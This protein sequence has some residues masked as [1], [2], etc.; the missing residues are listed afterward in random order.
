MRK[1]IG[2]VSSARHHCVRAYMCGCRIGTFA[3]V[4]FP[5]VVSVWVASKCLRVAI[6]AAIAVRRFA[7]GKSELLLLIPNKTIH[8]FPPYTITPYTYTTDPF[9][10]GNLFSICQFCF[11]FNL[12]KWHCAEHSNGRNNNDN[13]GA[14]ILL[15]T[16]SFEPMQ[17]EYVIYGNWNNVGG[18]MHGE[19]NIA[20]RACTKRALRATHRHNTQPNLLNSSN[21]NWVFHKFIFIFF[22]VHF[23]VAISSGDG[24]DGNEWRQSYQHWSLKG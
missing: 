22:F 13:N 20:T 18:F 19:T 6:G 15:T 17:Y 11:R 21:S 16:F 7:C 9:L 3:S 5:N 23:P 12:K 2:F 14:K 24:G 8:W 1:F 4:D 10:V